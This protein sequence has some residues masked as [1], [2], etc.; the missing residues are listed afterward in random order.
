MYIYIVGT[1]SIREG[2]VDIPDGKPKWDGIIDQS[3]LIE[4]TD[5][6]PE[7][8]MALKKKKKKKKK[9]KE[10][11]KE[12]KKKKRKREDS[13]VHVQLATSPA[14]LYVFSVS[15][16]GPS[17]IAFKRK[18]LSML[19]PSLNMLRLLF[20]AGALY[21]AHCLGGFCASCYVCTYSVGLLGWGIFL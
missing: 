1:L 10:T 16:K 4:D 11:N 5:G 8:K 15:A 2:V 20:A 14:P 3:D 7:L 18:L 17:S 6:P 13:E 12:K 9:K 19:I 21:F